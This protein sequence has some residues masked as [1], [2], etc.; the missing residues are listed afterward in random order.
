[1]CHRHSNLKRTLLLAL[2]VRIVAV[3]GARAGV[4]IAV[5]GVSVVHATTT[6][7]LIHLTEN[8][9]MRVCEKIYI[10]RGVVSLR[11]I[12]SRSTLSYQ[13]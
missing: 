4:I 10:R 13:C 7:G 12:H 1:M 2:C 11:K 6:T 3:V 5:R 8:E 9:C